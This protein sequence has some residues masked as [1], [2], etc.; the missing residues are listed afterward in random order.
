[1]KNV[2]LFGAAY[3]AIGSA[4]VVLHLLRPPSNGIRKIQPEPA[5]SGSVGKPCAEVRR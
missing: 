4:L 1:M 5:P 2:I 3:A